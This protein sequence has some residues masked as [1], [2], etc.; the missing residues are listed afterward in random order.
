VLDTLLVSVTD[1]S[2]YGYKVLLQAAP[3]HGNSQ[4]E[5]R[6]KANPSLYLTIMLLRYSSITAVE[7]RLH[8]LLNS[9]LC[10]REHV[11]VRM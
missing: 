4:F 11:A 6:V 2:S 7:A 9:A 5:A 10:T 8:A 1:R 3:S